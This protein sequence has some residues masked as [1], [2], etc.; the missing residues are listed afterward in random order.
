MI[1]QKFDN[2][3]SNKII[4][5]LTGASRSNDGIYNGE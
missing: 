1:V 3:R 5:L 4:A 2:D